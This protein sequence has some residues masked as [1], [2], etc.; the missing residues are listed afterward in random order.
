M[1][2]PLAGQISEML[3][4]PSFDIL[5]GVKFTTIRDFKSIDRTDSRILK[6]I[7]LPYAPF[8]VTYDSGKD[9]W[10]KPEG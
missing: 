4:S 2:T 10:I 7:E 1:S 3:A 8:D 5:A 6:I 9:T